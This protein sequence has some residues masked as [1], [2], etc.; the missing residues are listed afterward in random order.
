MI[1]SLQREFIKQIY[2]VKIRDERDAKVEDFHISVS[3]DLII[4]SLEELKDQELIDIIIV[5]Y[6]I[7][8]R[9]TKIGRTKIKVVLTGGAY[10]LLHTGH[11]TT[12]KEAASYGDFLLVVVARDSTVEGHKRKPIHSEKQRRD[13]LNELK[14]VDIAVIG[15]RTDHMAV[16]R[17]AIP[18]VVAIGSDQDHRIKLLQ[19]Q[20]SEEGISDTSLIRLTSNLEGLSTSEVITEI[21]ERF[22]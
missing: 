20:L 21:L 14:I 18:D 12:L 10:D 2:L 9:L 4:Q 3:T 19:N 5:D 15:D 1:S 16:V 11:I 22:V 17:K 7:F 6:E 8:Y 13:L